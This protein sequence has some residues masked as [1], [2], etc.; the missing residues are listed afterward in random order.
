MCWKLG[1]LGRDDPSCVA[2]LSCCLDVWQIKGWVT[3]IERRWPNVILSLMCVSVFGIAVGVIAPVTAEI[4]VIG[5]SDRV[6]GSGIMF[7]VTLDVPWNAPEVVVYLYL[8]GVVEIWTWF[9]TS[10]ALLVGGR[11]PL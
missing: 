11:K 1:S 7:D 4:L 10:W 6:G 5:L 8:D 2:A 3:I 9:R